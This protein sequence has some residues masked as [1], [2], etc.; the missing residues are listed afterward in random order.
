MNRPRKAF[1]IAVFLTLIASLFMPNVALVWMADVGDKLNFPLVPLRHGADLVA[2][3]F[4]PA[5]SGRIERM[6]EEELQ[7]VLDERAFWRARYRAAQAQIFDLQEELAQ[8]TRLNWD[9]D[10]NDAVSIATAR[11]TGH[12]PA[13]RQAGVEIN[14]GTELG[15][16][17]GAIAVYRGTHLVG[18]VSRVWP[19]RSIVSPI[20]HPSNSFIRAQVMAPN[21][22]P[23]DMGPP[24]YIQL[25]AT[26]DGTLV[27]VVDREMDIAVGDWV[28]LDDEAWS[29][30]AQ[31]MVLGGVAAVEAK[32][33][34]PL[35]N[36]VI[37]QPFYSVGAL[38]QVTLIID[39]PPTVADG[40]TP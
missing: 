28:H 18:H 1:P 2:E 12:N 27:A 30:A 13:R 10:D 3:W 5:P 4:R 16:R 29:P 17:R 25:S 38:S 24:K 37:V 23:D 20:T 7:T 36:D 19:L 21:T 31:M 39:Q 9:F 32:D 11:I 40:S 26:D 15:V 8:V 35:L 33:D 34:K 22:D 14:I 6:S